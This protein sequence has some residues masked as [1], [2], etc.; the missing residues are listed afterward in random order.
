MPDPFARYVVQASQQISILAVTLEKT[1]R[2]VSLDASLRAPVDPYV[3]A[4]LTM[5][6]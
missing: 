3:R 2:N 6:D 1:A 4:C 5:L